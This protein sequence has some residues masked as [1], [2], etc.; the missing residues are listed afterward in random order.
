MRF[1]VVVVVVVVVVLVA[2]TVV[3]VQG[4]D[5]VENKGILF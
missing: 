1:H 5:F 4:S 2:V 3:A